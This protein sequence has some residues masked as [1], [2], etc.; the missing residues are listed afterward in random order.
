[1]GSPWCLMPGTPRVPREP[2]RGAVRLGVPSVPLAV[3]G[4]SRAL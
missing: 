2:G 1:M 4:P 3:P